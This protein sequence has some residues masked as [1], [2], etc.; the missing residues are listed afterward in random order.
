ML[1][2]SLEAAEWKGNEKNENWIVHSINHQKK[3]SGLL[4]QKQICPNLSHWQQVSKKKRR[5]KCLDQVAPASTAT[6]P[7]SR[8]RADSTRFISGEC[9]A[10]NP[11]IFR[12]STPSRPL[13]RRVWRP[14]ASGARIRPS[15]RSPS[16]FQSV[17]VHKNAYN[18]GLSRKSEK[19]HLNALQ[20]LQFGL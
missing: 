3:L 8:R 1:L 6:S 19:V 11:N 10:D 9:G 14:S 18:Q 12:W 20:S 7:S 17:F 13:T 15:S 2:V 5:E 4:F 16:V